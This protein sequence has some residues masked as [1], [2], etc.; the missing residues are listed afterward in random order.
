M[1]DISAK[2]LEDLRQGLFRELKEPDVSIDYYRR[3]LQRA[4]VQQL[5]DLLQ[6][7][8]VDSDLPALARSELTAIGKAVGSAVDK[9]RAVPVA[10][11]LNDLKA[12]IDFALDPRVQAKQP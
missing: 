7:P 10:A 5:A 1:V 3:N 6:K 9:S 2:L 11:H 8:A 12:R 4:Y